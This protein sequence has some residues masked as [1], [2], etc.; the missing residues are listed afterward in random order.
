VNEELTVEVTD[1]IG[2]VVY[3]GKIQAVNGSVDQKITLT[4]T[5]NGMYLLN[6]ASGTEHTVFHF[7]IE[8]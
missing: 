3:S 7:V 1:M 8:Q 5:A 2:Q 4:N 6:L